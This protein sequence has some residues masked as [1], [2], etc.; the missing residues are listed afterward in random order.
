M[1]T[2]I[3]T[4]LS[5]RVTALY[6]QALRWLK[7]RL[8]KPV[9]HLRV[10]F[11][12]LSLNVG[13]LLLLPVR[14]VLSIKAWIVRQIIRGSYNNLE[15][16]NAKHLATQLGLQ[17]QT[18]APQINQPAPIAQSRKRGRPVGSTKLAQSRSK[19]SKIAPI[20]TA[21]PSI[22]AGT[23][24]EGLVNQHLQHAKKSSKKER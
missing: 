10:S 19:G 17:P 9:R 11:I 7:A 23:K 14:I 15:P 4:Q 18:T 21:P 12:L 1:F 8:C 16:I 2:H 24:L 5:G 20:H 6:I 13:N 3:V 22:V